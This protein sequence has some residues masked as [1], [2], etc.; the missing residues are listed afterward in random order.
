VDI[1]GHI[2]RRGDRACGL[3]GVVDDLLA[4]IGR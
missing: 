3:V 4:L 2:R 1:G